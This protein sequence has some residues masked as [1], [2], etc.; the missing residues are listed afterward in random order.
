MWVMD[1]ALRQG[2]SNDVT[3]DALMASNFAAIHTSSNVRNYIC[4]S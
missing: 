1:E 4:D 3:I 2:E